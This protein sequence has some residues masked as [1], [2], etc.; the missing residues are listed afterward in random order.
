MLAIWHIA[1]KDLTLVIRDRAGLFWLLAFPLIMALFFG[2]VFGG[3]GD[4]GGKG[5]IKLAFVDQTR[6][7]QYAKDFKDLI[8]SSEA[9]RAIPTTLDSARDLVRRGKRQAFVLLTQ[10]DSAEKQM[11]EMYPGGVP[12]IEVGIDP[13]RGAETAMLEGLLTQAHFSLVMGRF[14][15]PSLAKDLFSSGV[16]AIDSAKDIPEDQRTVLRNMFSGLEGFFS[17]SATDTAFAGQSQRDGGGP[18]SKPNITVTEVI[19]EREGPRSSFEITFPQSL[20]WALIGCATAF[21]LSIVT[22]R[23]KGTLI[24]LRLAPLTR[25]HII[26]GKALACFIA[27]LGVCTIL[28]SIGVLV[29]G[30]SLAEPLKLLLAIVCS[31]ICFVGI[32]MLISNLGKTEQ[33]VAG[34]GWAI[35]L[36]MSMT[37]GGMVPLIA[38]PKWMITIG[39]ISPVRWGITALEGAIWRDYSFAELGEPLAVLLGIGIGGFVAGVKLLSRDSL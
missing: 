20:M 25:A 23:T 18:F 34:A 9:L 17:R 3:F 8:D 38:M 27:C 2:S 13:A 7:G 36:I 19:R 14:T 5:R 22:E 10:P 37:G 24:R 21:S 11:F 33:A 35:L 12:R 15:D 30:V 31:A 4:S 6:G 29:F 1:L 39:S 28:M 26:G 16:A 32:M